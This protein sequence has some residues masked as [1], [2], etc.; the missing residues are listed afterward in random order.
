MRGL[1]GSDQMTPGRA[2]IECHA[3]TPAAPQY[4]IAGTIYADAGRHDA[5][6]CNGVDGIG[7]AVA[8]LMDNGS[9]IGPRLQLN[10]VGNFFTS[11][12]MPAQYRVKV[13]AQGVERVMQTPVTNGDCNVCHS[14]DGKLGASGRL[15]KPRP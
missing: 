8:L 10:A 9:E 2:C 4:S 5:D 15:V 14:A 11:R 3:K 1:Q 13:I 12:T 7:I 6:D